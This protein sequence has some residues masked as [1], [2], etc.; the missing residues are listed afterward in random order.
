MAK[1]NVADVLVDTLAGAGVD[2]SGEDIRRVGR[3]AQ[4]H[5]RRDSP[6]RAPALDAR[7]P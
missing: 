7:A 6:T 4:R 2:G 3:L 1:K 5:H